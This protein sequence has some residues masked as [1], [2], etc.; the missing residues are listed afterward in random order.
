MDGAVVFIFQEAGQIELCSF[1]Q[2]HD[3]AHLKCRSCCPRSWAISQTTF[4]K[5]CLHMRS[6]VLFLYHQIS[7]TATVPGQYFWG[8]F[9][10]AA[11][12]NS[13]WGPFLQQWALFSSGLAPPLMVLT[14]H[15]C[16]QFLGWGWP[17]QSLH[18]LQPFCCLPPP[19]QLPQWGW[20][21][22]NLCLCSYLLPLLHLPPPPLP[23]LGITLILAMLEWKIH[24]YHS[25]S[26]V[27]CEYDLIL[28]LFELS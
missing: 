8:F 23:L 1:L 26:L 3:C 27:C 16:H 25:N 22:R 20:N 6:S 14:V 13:F 9:N 24:D 12:Q 21:S 19:L 5:G 7:Q 28:V 4:I 2:S 11:F 17:R 18:L 10:G 15:L